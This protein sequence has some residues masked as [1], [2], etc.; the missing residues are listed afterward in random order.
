MRCIRS[1]VK[2]SALVPTNYRLPVW[3]LSLLHT[4]R[5]PSARKGHFICP[6]IW[7]ASTT[8]PTSKTSHSTRSE[9]AFGIT[10]SP[11]KVRFDSRLLTMAEANES[12]LLLAL[13]GYEVHT[14]RTALDWL[15][16]LD[17]LQGQPVDISLWSLLIS[18]D[19]MGRVGYSR[20]WG[21]VRGGQHSRMLGLLEAAFRPIGKMGR[22]QWPL[23]IINQL[24]LGDDF[25]QFGVLAS[26]TIDERAN[27]KRNIS[28]ASMFG[29]LIL[30]SH[31]IR[32]NEMISRNISLRTIEQTVPGH[33]AASQCYT[34]SRRLSSS[35][36]RK[37]PFRSMITP[38]YKSLEILSPASWRGDSIS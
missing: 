15:A 10:L 24:Q 21:L 27:V 14:R 1:M 12:S 31:R 28:D 29:T 23:T 6:F 8:L 19:N 20:E 18:F 7:M 37:A 4:D 17:T 3:K 38:P 36:P 30:M 9:D 26:E 2:L 22:L 13:N 32:P 5:N 25:K 11:Q 33:Q 35:Q 16:K 34:Q